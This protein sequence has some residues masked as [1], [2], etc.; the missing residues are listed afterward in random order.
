[1]KRNKKPFIIMIV[2][3]FAV[4]VVGS[5][6]TTYAWFLSRYG[7]EYD[8]ELNSESPMILKYETDLDFASGT[9]S[10]LSNV[11]VPATEKSVSAGI[12][13]GA[14]SPLDVFDVDTLS[15]AHTG[16][17]AQAAHAVKYTATAAYWTGEGEQAGAF[18]PEL[19]V[20]TNAFLGSTALTTHLGTFSEEEAITEGNLLSVLSEEAYEVAAANRLIARNDLVGQG[21]VSYILVIDYLGKTFLYYDGAYYVSGGETDSDFTL[22]EAMESDPE[23]RYWHDPTAENSTV[24]GSLITDGSYFH[25]LPNTGF[26]FTLYVFM[27]RTDEKLDPAVNGQRLSLFMSLTVEEV[28]EAVSPEEPEEP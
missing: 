4:L 19:H 25:L 13:Q 10:D 16:A 14:L 9:D 20:Y 3:V 15:P 21:E 24:S 22:P 6:M 7:S 23:L 8:F 26:S 2:S 5:V 11:L 12:S 28:N 1:M 18:A 27:A 17:V